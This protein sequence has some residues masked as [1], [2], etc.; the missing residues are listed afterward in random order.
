MR[1]GEDEVKTKV[2]G[3]EQ[4]SELAKLD[5]FARCAQD[6]DSKVEQKPSNTS[7]AT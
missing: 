7:L 1:W 2:V 3:G 6:G 4:A 5:F